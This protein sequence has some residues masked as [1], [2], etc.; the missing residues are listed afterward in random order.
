MS[1]DKESLDAEPSVTKRLLVESDP[2]QARVAVLENE[3]LTEIHMERRKNRSVVGNV[4]KGRVSRILPGMQAAFV[5]VG[6][7]RDAFLYVGDV[8]DAISDQDELADADPQTKEFPPL[9]LRPIEKLL[10]EGQELI[11]QVVK[12]PL[13]NK[14]ARITT[15]ITLPGRYAVF[16]PTVDNLGISRRITDLEER[17]RLRQVLERALPPDGG[18]IVRT[19]GE[20]KEEKD[21]VVDIDYLRGCWKLI[22]SSATKKLAPSLLHEDQELVLRAVR[23]RFTDDFSELLVDGTEAYERIVEF[24]GEVAPW[25]LDRIRLFEDEGSLFVQLGIEREIDTAL[26]SKVWLKSGGYI[27]VNPTEALVAIDV[28]TGRFVG[29]K[30]LEATVLQTNLEAVEEIVRQI[31]LRDLSGIIVVDLIDM[32][33]AEHREEV[34]AVL[35]RELRRD[36]AKHQV[37]SL[38]DFGLVEITRKRSRENLSRILTRPCP[39]CGGSGRI[40]SLSTICLKLRREILARGNEIGDRKLIVQ[41]H[42]EVSWILETD[43]HDILEELREALGEQLAIESDEGL[44]HEQYKIT[45]V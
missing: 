24:A 28:N 45:E 7:A 38:S 30:N 6:L 5:D 23:D 9:E 40:L 37:L 14:G 42:P 8:R 3:R 16:V 15:E 19:A 35:Q 44:H 39:E 2:H 34:F 21:F 41:V 29:Q 12:A 32:S 22:Q 11:V 4:Y 43:H 17:E 18:L 20:G 1:I 27:V 31:R 13:P 33:E 10:S 36:R 25:L 26:K